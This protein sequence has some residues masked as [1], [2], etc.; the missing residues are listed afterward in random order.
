MHCSPA[1]DHTSIQVEDIAMT[2]KFPKL[3]TAAAAAVLISV[4]SASAQAPQTVNPDASR[5]EIQERVTPDAR[6]QIGETF[7]ALGTP[8]ATGVTFDPTPGAVVP[9]GLQTHPVPAEVISVFPDARD[10]HYVTLPD[11]RTALVH[12]IDR[13]VV[14]VFD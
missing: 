9:E 13:D 11:G 5:G 4:G 12:P 7:R 3:L 1:T 6:T 10:Y 14:M 8:P 2:N